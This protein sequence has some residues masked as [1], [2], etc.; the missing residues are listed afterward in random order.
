MP[1][2]ETMKTLIFDSYCSEVMIGITSQFKKLQILR[3][4][5]WQFLFGEYFPLI[6]SQ[7]LKELDL[8]GSHQIEFEYINNLVSQNAES[9]RVL[10]VDGENISGSEFND[11][12][13]T[14][15]GLETFWVYY[16]QNADRSLLLALWKH[17]NMLKKLVLRK[18]EEFQEDDFDTLFR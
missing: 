10:R 16:A 14:I 15:E 7:C 3:L 12:V 2:T 17:R 5:D 11:L 8:S 18:N 9:L 4:I 1:N 6:K 13:E